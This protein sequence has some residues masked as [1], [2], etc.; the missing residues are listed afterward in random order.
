MAKKVSVFVGTRK[1]A[2]ILLSD[3]KRKDWKLSDPIFLGHVIYHITPDARDNTRLVMGAKTGHLG[4]TTYQSSDRGK[5][6]KEAAA[7]PA[8]PKIED[9][10]NGKGGKVVEHVFW[11]SPGHESDS[12]RWYAGTSPPG[13]FVS[14]DHGDNWQT[15]AGFNDN[16]NYKEWLG[17]GGTP[18]G[19][20]LHSINIDPTNKKHMYVAVSSGGVFES[21]DQGKTWTPLNKGCA[22]DFNPDPDPEY[23]HDPHCVVLHPQLPTRL[24]QQNHCGIYK[25]DR[26]SREWIRIGNNM[27]KEVGD[28]GFPIVVHPKNAD[29]AWVFPMDGSDV[30]PRTS[31][32][33][34]PCVYMTKDGGNS[35]QR[36]DT[37]LPSA[38][39]YFTVKRQA[40]TSDKQ[41]SVGL[42][43]GT[44]QGEVWASSDEGASWKCLVS[45]LPEIYSLSVLE[46]DE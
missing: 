16:P 7:P 37:G 1:G 32:G 25:I 9:D 24:Y 6:W 41:D 5:T 18:G 31:P 45:Y 17:E 39:G 20:M 22:A 26:P 29:V 38:N 44:S 15:V 43:F 14:D 8:F 10:A 27:P 36:R 40:M 30:W 34:K 35:W 23:G 33:G 2:F 13:L 21:E 28:I 11:V 42:Y 3:D 4:P 19:Q 12:G 46:Y